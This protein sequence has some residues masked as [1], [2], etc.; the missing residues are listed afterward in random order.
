MFIPTI[1]KIAFLWM[2]LTIL[3]PAILLLDPDEIAV[4]L[5]L[6]LRLDLAQRESTRA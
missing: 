4:K 1:R 3:T 5:P 2:V 6:T